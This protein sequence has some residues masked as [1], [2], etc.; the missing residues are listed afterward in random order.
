MKT[1]DRLDKLHEHYSALACLLNVR[2]TVQP[3]KVILPLR[4]VS[5]LL[6]FERTCPEKINSKFLLGVQTECKC[7]G[8]PIKLTVIHFSDAAMLTCAL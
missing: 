5:L 3:K 7:Y 6:T 1:T 2:D 4:S 8:K